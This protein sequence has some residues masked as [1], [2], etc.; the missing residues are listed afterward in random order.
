MW[1]NF[2]GKQFYQ[3]KWWKNSMRISKNSMLTDASKHRQR[4]DSEQPCFWIKQLKLESSTRQ[5]WHP[6]KK[7]SGNLP[8]LTCQAFITCYLL[9]S[10]KDIPIS[11]THSPKHKI[12]YCISDIIHKAHHS[13]FH[14]LYDCYDVNN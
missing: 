6:I 5:N 12:F 7:R 14:V 8:Y 4:H 10:F 3:K 2:P 13:Q 9:K 11:W 1:W